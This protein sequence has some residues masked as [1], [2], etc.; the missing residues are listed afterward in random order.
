MTNEKPS[1]SDP[2]EDDLKQKDL[3]EIDDDCNEISSTLN[4]NVHLEWYRKAMQKVKLDKPKKGT[5]F[6]NSFSKKKKAI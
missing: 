3:I 1:T 6:Q 2:D 4:A 5:A